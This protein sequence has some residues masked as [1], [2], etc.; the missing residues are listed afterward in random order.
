MILY[1]YAT[2]HFKSVKHNVSLNP[3]IYRGYPPFVNPMSQ[4]SPIVLQSN[5]I[6]ATSHSPS[7]S[8]AARGTSATVGRL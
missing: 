8:V 5:C 4:T 3:R 7:L 6:Y 1:G 2:I